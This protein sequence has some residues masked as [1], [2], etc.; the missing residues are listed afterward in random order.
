MEVGEHAQRG[1]SVQILLQDFRY[2]LRQLRRSPGF[3]AIAVVTLALGIGANTAIFSAVHAVLLKPLPYSDADRLV[4]VWEQNPHRGWFE[5]IVSAANYLDWRQQNHVFSGLAAFDDISFTLVGS[6]TPQE[7]PAQRVTSSLFS[8]LGVQPLRGR[9]FLPEEDKPG[10]SPVAVLS[11]G[12]WQQ[13]Y[14]G[15]PALVGKQISLN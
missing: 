11:Y 8:V 3:T 5:N 15:D 10:S 13:H 2:A 7:I 4:V 6:G 1:N 14:G 9:V 12:L